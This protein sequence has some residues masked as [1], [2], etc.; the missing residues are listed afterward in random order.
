MRS[1]VLGGMIWG[2]A[3]AAVW[4]QPDPLPDF[5]TCM[6]MTVA[7]YEQDLRRLRARPEE[8]RDFDIGD[9]RGV[10]FCGTV[11][12]VRC[13]RSEDPL[14]CQRRLSA[15]QDALK[16]RVLTL[17]PA[18]DTVPGAGFA[19][20]L[21][22]QVWELAQGR[23]AGPDCAG[24]EPAMQAWCE[25]REANSRLRSAV[26]AW[27]VARFLGVADPAVEAGWAKPPPPVRPHA[28]P[29]GLKP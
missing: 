29:E 28:R 11:G 2:S 10:D 25:A 26:L 23:S 18:P 21:Y 4:A 15:E 12:I 5:A 6:D 9:V 19:H 7:R 13:D 14:P 24:Q 17:L 22:P 16:D 20:A 1:L 8:A 3:A 27:Q